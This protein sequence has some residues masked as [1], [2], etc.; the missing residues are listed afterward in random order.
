MT[1]RERDARWWRE[2]ARD[3]E[4]RSRRVTLPVEYVSSTTGTAAEKREVVPIC[5]VLDPV[6]WCPAHAE[7]SPDRARRYRQLQA[8]GVSTGREWWPEYPEDTHQA[9]DLRATACCLIAAMVE[10]GDA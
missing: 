2:L 1:Q 8:I 9:F 5:G 7:L 3:Y 4:R 10:A 6:L